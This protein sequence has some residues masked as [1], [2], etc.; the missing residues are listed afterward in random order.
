[1]KKNLLCYISYYGHFSGADEIMVTGWRNAEQAAATRSRENL[2]YAQYHIS[3]CDDD[4]N[5][6]KATPYLWLREGHSI[7]P[8]CVPS[9]VKDK[10]LN[11][12]ID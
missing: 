10:V 4:G 5:E 8:D 12:F 7:H 9:A 11:M 2:E 3:G 1:M 6:V